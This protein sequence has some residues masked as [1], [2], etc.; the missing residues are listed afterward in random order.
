MK[1]RRRLQRS[2]LLCKTINLE[3]VVITSIEV[4]DKFLNLN[5]DGYFRTTTNNSQVLSDSLSIF[6]NK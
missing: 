1:R 2:T 6:T 4:V 3:N 5:I